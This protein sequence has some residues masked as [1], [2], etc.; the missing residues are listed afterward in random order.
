M[1]WDSVNGILYRTTI[2]SIRALGRLD[3][4]TRS[5]ASAMPER[6]VVPLRRERRNEL[7]QIAVGIQELASGS[8]DLNSDRVGYASLQSYFATNANH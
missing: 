4:R 3:L 1:V 8:G 5:A 7:P 6:T 2:T